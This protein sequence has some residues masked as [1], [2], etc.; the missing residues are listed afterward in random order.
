MAIAASTVL[1]TGS[2]ACNWLKK[3]ANPVERWKLGYRP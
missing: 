1:A 3:G 2:K